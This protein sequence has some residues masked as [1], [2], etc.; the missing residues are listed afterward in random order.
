M[1]ALE[2]AATAPLF[3]QLTQ[4][5]RRDIDS[6]LLAPGSR[7]PSVRQMAADCAVSTIT[8]VNA[9][10]Q[11]VADGY[12]Q[13]RP[14]SGYYVCAP[15]RQV[16]APARATMAQAQVDSRWLLSHLFADESSMLLPGC[17]WF[18]EDWLEGEQLRDALGTLARK[19]A[20]SLVRYGNPY[21]YLPLRQALQQ[22]LHARAIEVDTDQIILTQGATQALNLCARLFLE[23]G[24]TVLVD[25]P[26]YANLLAMLRT[27]G[28]KTIGVPRTASGPD[29]AALEALAALHRP[30]LFFTNTNLQNPTGTST[31]LA[32]AHRIL[33]AAET[34]DFHI[35]ED[36]IFADLQSERSVSL[37]ALD[38]LERVSYIGSLTKSISPSL[39]VGFLVCKRELAREF[40]QRKML[41]GLTSS[42]LSEKLAA[43]ILGKGRQR[44]SIERLRGRCMQ[45]QHTVGAR[46]E[47]CGMELFHRP[48]GGMFLWARFSAGIDTNEVTLRAAER[49]I[50]LAPGRLFSSAEGAGAWM[51]VNVAHADKPAF[52]RFIEEVAKGGAAARG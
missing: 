36:D 25:D 5:L 35:I 17:G 13:A 16:A 41:E 18:P 24:D 43:I 32:T 37:A 3:Q 45:A 52:Y 48:A 33:R 22:A 27:Q 9:Y 26:M 12:L 44:H 1:Y 14:A 20:N 34:Y 4:L 51:R 46:L 23:P 10:N 49:D 19:N 30:K 11:L 21:G 28:Y 29:P 47:Q 7:L 31:T 42:E 15:S 39:R 40:A 6:A 38:Q 2:R 50:V 8:V